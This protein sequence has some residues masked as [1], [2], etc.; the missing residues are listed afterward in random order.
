MR[1]AW[2]GYKSY[3]RLR[4]G[5]AVIFYLA[6]MRAPV[7]RRPW[8][9]TWCLRHPCRRKNKLDAAFELRQNKQSATFPSHDALIYNQA[10][11]RQAALN[12]LNF[13]PCQA[14]FKKLVM[15]YYFC[16]NECRCS[17]YI[18]K[19]NKTVRNHPVYKQN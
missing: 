10:M 13:K 15:G 2:L 12:L 9:G 6:L 7:T 1:W 5:Q 16:Y 8:L 17:T 14:Q 18:K 11:P 4:H 19:N 3:I